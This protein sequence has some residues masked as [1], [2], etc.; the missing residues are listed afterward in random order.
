M[1]PDNMPTI[2]TCPTS[3]NIIINAS[4]LQRQKKKKK[5]DNIIYTY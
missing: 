1:H 2:K 4:L 5:I 3:F